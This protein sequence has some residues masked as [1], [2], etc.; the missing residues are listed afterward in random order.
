M[1]VYIGFLCICTLRV[2]GFDFFYNN[3]NH[4]LLWGPARINSDKRHGPKSSDSAWNEIATSASDN[5]PRPNCD[6]DG[7]ADYKQQAFI[8]TDTRRFK[9]QTGDMGPPPPPS[10]AGPLQGDCG[11]S[12][13]SSNR[14][15]SL[16]EAITKVALSP[17]NPKVPKGFPKDIH[18]RP[19]I[20]M[21]LWQARTS[22][23]ERRLSDQAL[24]KT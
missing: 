9:T 14:P 23:P 22:S 12:S 1:V 2:C 20:N 4:R 18:F 21:H 11:I 10:L 17:P 24:I 16:T 8:N 13:K 6:S 3:I 15:E 7:K 5:L 19:A